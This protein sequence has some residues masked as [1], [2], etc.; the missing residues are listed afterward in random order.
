[1]IVVSGLSGA[2][3]TI[4]L[5]CLEDMGYYCVDNMPVNLLPDLQK[6]LSHSD[7]PIA[8][9]IDIRNP[10]NNLRLFPALINELK[11]QAPDT[12]L[13]FLTATDEVLI[14]RFSESKRK[15]P[16]ARLYPSLLESIADERKIL[17]PLT[18]CADHIIDSSNLNIYQL[19]DR[20]HLWLESSLRDALTVNC[21]SFGFKNGVP[22]DADLMFDVRFLSNPYWDEALRPYCG[23]DQPIVDYLSGF[24]ETQD[25]L[26][27]TT[28]YLNQWLPVY[29]RSN[30]A[31]LT[32]A[33]G[34]TGGKHR[35]VFITESIASLLQ[36][37]QNEITITHRDLIRNKPS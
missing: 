28:R 15:H 21:L 34:C 23:L 1:M 25:F 20:I 27:S 31:Y 2:G 11:T 12:R 14:K 24:Q 18:T 17:S 37:E 16:L 10:E 22:I 35:S 6:E 19:Q 8:V 32:I 26:K 5:H 36:K 13:L 7:S 29:A 4:A 9:G 33:F 3:K 30:R